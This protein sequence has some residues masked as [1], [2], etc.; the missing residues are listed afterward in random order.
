M[1]DQKNSKKKQ[2][3]N[4]TEHSENGVLDNTSNT[5]PNLKPDRIELPPLD[6]PTPNR[7]WT[8]MKSHA[9]VSA[10]TEEEK[11]SLYFGRS[12]I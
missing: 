1:K 5:I 2:N 11:N 12:N 9:D 7:A 3:A 8:E 10:M 4:D 6:P